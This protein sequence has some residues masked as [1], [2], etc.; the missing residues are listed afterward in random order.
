[1]TVINNLEIE[2]RQATF[3]RFLNK[4]GLITDNTF[5]GIIADMINNGTPK[6]AWRQANWKAWIENG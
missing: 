6:S 3:L 2:S 5:I 1:M 4:F